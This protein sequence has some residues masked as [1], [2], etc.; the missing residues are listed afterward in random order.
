MDSD[1]FP[2]ITESGRKML[3]FLAEHPNAPIFRNKSGNRL[4]DEDIGF[5]RE[6][7]KSIEESRP[8]WP[9]GG[10]PRWI[11]D[12][13]ADCIESVPFYRRYGFPGE[14]SALPLVSR[15][16]L[17]H[18]ISAFVPD[19]VPIDR[20]VN[21]RTSG[22]SGHPLLI[23]SHPRV[24]AS[25]LLYLKRALG[26]FGIELHNGKGQVGVLLVGWQKECFTY[27]SVTPIMDESGLAKINLHPDDWKSP[28]DRWKYIDALR[29][30]VITG[31]PDRKS[32][33]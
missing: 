5:L 8:G 25:Y 29:P 32:V 4:T 19:T 17:G 16:D 13:V 10:Q 26:R 23:A 18:D 20:L 2:S 15:A 6:R 21:Y 11:D 22:T 31:D 3:L 24:A 27:V 7:E 9:K 1:R 30:E 14:L 12:F 28:D 33:V